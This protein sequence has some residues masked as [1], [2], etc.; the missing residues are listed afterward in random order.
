MYLK[1]ICS[2]ACLSLF[3]LIGIIAQ[4]HHYT[5]GF[6]DKNYLLNLKIMEVSDTATRFNISVGHLFGYC[7]DIEGG[8]VNLLQTEF[9]STPHIRFLNKPKQKRYVYFHSNGFH[10]GG[11]AVGIP[12]QNSLSDF[13]Y[14]GLSQTARDTTP[15]RYLNL[16]GRDIVMEVLKREFNFD[17]KVLSN[18]LDVLE[19]KVIDATKLRHFTIPYNE[20]NKPNNGCERFS[21]VYEYM[22]QPK[23]CIK[24]ILTIFTINLERIWNVY[25]EDKTNSRPQG[26]FLE[27]PTEL[28]KS[29]EMLPQLDHYLK[30][31]YGL[32]LVRKK[33][34]RTVFNIQFND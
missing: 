19:L 6:F 24:T 26:Y 3:P 16:H 28:F 14:K 31:Q 4:K 29:Y 9:G 8:V 30:E 15:S 17:V 33:E 7:G 18:S 12:T 10:M 22:P 23:F 21:L 25:V 34:Y 11:A 5:N 13:F 27:F 20:I 32:T 2:T 1:N